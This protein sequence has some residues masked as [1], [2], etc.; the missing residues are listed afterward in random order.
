[1]KKERLKIGIIALMA[2]LLA[3]PALDAAY[4]DIMMTHKVHTDAFQMRGR[5]M[6]ARDFVQTIWMADKMMRNDSDKQSAIFRMDKNVIYILDT[7]H[8]NY[9]EIPMDLAKSA[10]T[11]GAPPAG[12]RGRAAQSMKEQAPPGNFTMHVTVADTGETKKIN[13]WKCRKFLQKVD[14][15]MAPVTAEV[16]ATEDLKMNFD[17]FAQ[18]SAAMM[19][20]QPGAKESIKEAINEM[21]KIRGVPVLMT[22]TTRAMGAEIKTS[23]ELIDF[24]EAKAPA[25]IFEIPPDYVKK[26]MP[27]FPPSM[28]GRQ[29]RPAQ[30]L[31]APVQNPADVEPEE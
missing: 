9:T 31:Q 28:S 5:P 12:K 11:E 19:A 23:Q 22:S 4:A 17:L 27:E 21:K 26:D 15:P 18:F 2:G 6:P 30:R 29:G 13:K 10:A 16:W 8:K 24:K 1:M 20:I 14:M 3:M 25:G 7:W